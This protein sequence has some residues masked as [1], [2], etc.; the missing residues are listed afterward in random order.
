MIKIK[1]EFMK[2]L[3]LL[4]KTILLISTIGTTAIV[5]AALLG[6]LPATPGGTDYQVYYDDAADL[7]WLKEVICP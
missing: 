5:N 2:S 4:I 1:E 7:T 3:N 6:R